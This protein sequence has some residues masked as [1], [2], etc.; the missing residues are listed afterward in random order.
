MTGKSGRKS[1]LGGLISIEEEPKSAKDDVSPA[2]VVRERA[3]A[4]APIPETVSERPPMTLES[5]MG[6]AP[7]PTPKKSAPTPTPAPAGDS[8]RVANL[9]AEVKKHVPTGN[10]TLQ[11]M[12]AMESLKDVLSDPVVRRNAALKVLAT[13]GVTA[14]AVAS[15]EHE[16]ATVIDRCF[17][18]LL[19][20]ADALRVRDVEGKR[21]EA[22]G[23]RVQADGKRAEI[24]AINQTITG[25]EREA[26]TLD[27]DAQ[28]RDG[29]IQGLKADIETARIAARASYG[30]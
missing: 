20:Q 9:V 2:T 5:I 29:E 3:S 24:E 16:V 25:L 14:E 27:R 1:L 30:V 17:D 15:G 13:Q 11:L 21:T 28:T 4:P 22:Q 26:V 19:Q 23:L 7:A 12:T 6:G 10:A 18:S 8:G